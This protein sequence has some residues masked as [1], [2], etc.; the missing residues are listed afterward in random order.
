MQGRVLERGDVRVKRYLGFWCEGWGLR[1]G[2]HNRYPLG[3]LLVQRLAF[4]M[5]RLFRL[6]FQPRK[7]EKKHRFLLVSFCTA[8][9]MLISSSGV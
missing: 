8:K 9:I 6:G 4:P 1:E 2:K 5:Y 3:F 7:E